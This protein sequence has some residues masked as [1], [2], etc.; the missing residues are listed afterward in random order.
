M[1]GE[2]SVKAFKAMILGNAIGPQ[3]TWV[4]SIQL[5]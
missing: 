1:G 2:G 4:D 5:N 3:F